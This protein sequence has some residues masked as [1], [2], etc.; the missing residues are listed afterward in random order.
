MIMGEG[1]VIS[2]ELSWADALKTYEGSELDGGEWSASRP[3]R[4]TPGVRAPTTP[5]VGGWVVPRAGLD[6]V[7]KKFPAPAKYRTPVVQPVA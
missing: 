4:F 7:T 3:G 6:A 2:I 1:K 5:W